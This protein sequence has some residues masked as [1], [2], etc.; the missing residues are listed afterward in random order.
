M[1]RPRFR[2]RFWLLLFLGAV[3]AA[4]PMRAWAEPVGRASADFP[5]LRANKTE[6]PFGRLVADAI[7]NRSGAD[8]AIVNAG[9][10]KSGTLD[11]GPIENNDLEALLAFSE[12]DISTLSL[13]GAQLK[14]A[15]E[16]AASVFPTGSPAFLQ[17]AGLRARFDSSSPPGRRV[18]AVSVGGKP[19]D[20]NATYSVAMPSSLAEG[21]AGFFN[22]WNGA[23]KKATGANLIQ[24]LN[25]FIGA[26]GDVSPDSTAR[27]E[28]S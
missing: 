19:L 21:A 28:G 15:L 27:F 4:R 26:K 8:C 25:A 2:S 17:V 22:I 18:S 20:E 3:V 24:D 10:L 5:N 1:F 6:T 7:L 23:Q 11:A 9:A 12:D 16:R 14:A 13:S